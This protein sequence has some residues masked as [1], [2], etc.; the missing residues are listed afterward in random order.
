[1]LLGCFPVCV[2]GGA[3]HNEAV[4]IGHT[5]SFKLFKLIENISRVAIAKVRANRSNG[6]R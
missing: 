4:L 1:M 2:L 6:S 3:K 5:T